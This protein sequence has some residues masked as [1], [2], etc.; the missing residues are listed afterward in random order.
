MDELL[1]RKQKLENKIN[2]INDLLNLPLIFAKISLDDWFCIFIKIVDQRTLFLCSHVC[3]SWRK[4]IIKYEKLLF[5]KDINILNVMIKMGIDAK[6]QL[7]RY[8]YS[9]NS[10]DYLTFHLIQFAENSH[11]ENMIKSIMNNFKDIYFYR[12][13]N[14]VFISSEYYI[15]IFDIESKVQIFISLDINYIDNFSTK[16]E[17]LLDLPIIKI[18]WR[19]DRSYYNHTKGVFTIEGDY[20]KKFI[21]KSDS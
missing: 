17:F 3:S 16:G 5:R 1:L 20:L 11:H 13:E 15:S 8:I 21:K 2:Q 12:E 14:N 6:I 4:T 18:V 19:R 7:P 10:Q 9:Y